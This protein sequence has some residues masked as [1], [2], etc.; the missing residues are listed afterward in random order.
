MTWMGQL[1]RVLSAVFRQK[2]SWDGSRMG[3]SNGVSGESNQTQSKTLIVSPQEAFQ[4]VQAGAAVLVDVREK[5]ELKSGM[6]LSAQ[7]MPTSEIERKSENW[8]KFI[9]ELPKD[10]QIILYCGAGVRAG[11][12][13]HLL[14]SFGYRTA[15]CGGFKD[16]RNA[17]LPIKQN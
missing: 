4:A 7:W 6:A 1:T 10:K 14:S 2:P 13:A 3:D 5:N 16:W 11:R 8:E 17:R 9:Q 15:N 12:V